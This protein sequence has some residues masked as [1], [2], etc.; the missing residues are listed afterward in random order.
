MLRKDHARF[1][2]STFSVHGVLLAAL[3]MSRTFAAVA[4]KE[5]G[6]DY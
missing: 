5:G 1:H 2:Q 3:L 4:G 6:D